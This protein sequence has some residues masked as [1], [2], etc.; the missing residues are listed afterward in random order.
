M[1]WVNMLLFIIALAALLL[2]QLYRAKTILFKM[3]HDLETWIGFGTGDDI[4]RAKEH[5]KE[6]SHYVDICEKDVHKKQSIPK[7]VLILIR[8][9][10]EHKSVFL[11][12]YI[13][14]LWLLLRGKKI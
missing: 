1:I 9:D 2:S 13:K 7:N 6:Y 3:E 10:L 12:I 8:R 11:L 14:I 4:V 5:R